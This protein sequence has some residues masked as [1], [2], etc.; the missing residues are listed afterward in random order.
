MEIQSVIASVVLVSGILSLLCLLALHLVSPEFKPGWRM[1]SEYALGKYKWLLTLFFIFWSLSSLSSAS[2]LWPL[3]T[4][5]WA[6][7]GVLLIVVSGI[8]AFMGGLFDVNHKLHG[9]SALLGIP[10]L[11]AGTLLISYHLITYEQWT[12]H[13]FAI[14]T[15]AHITWISLVFM[16]ISMM[17]LFSGFKK[18]GIPMG[19]GVKPP[20]T[21]PEGVTGINGYANRI[22]IVSQIGWL[23]VIASIY[24]SL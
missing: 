23:L 3:V 1:V 19:P 21:L 7:A 8:G 17:I 9:L 4:S 2:L 6:R 18:A 13:R 24:L 14:L 15:A 10:T 20:S 5:I 12:I 22:L 11:P 16:A